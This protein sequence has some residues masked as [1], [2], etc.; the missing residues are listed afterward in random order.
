MSKEK[1]EIPKQDLELTKLL[2][3]QIA[4]DKDE[5]KAMDKNIVAAWC[6]YCKRCHYIWFPKDHS[7]YQTYSREKI[8]DE[9]I[10]DRAPPKSCARCKSKYWNKDPIR[11]TKY[12]DTRDEDWIM[13]PY[14]YRK[15]QTLPVKAK[16]YRSALKFFEELKNKGIL[17]NDYQKNSENFEKW[18]NEGQVDKSWNNRNEWN[19]HV[20]A[21]NDYLEITEQKR[22]EK[23]ERYY[24]KRDLQQQK[25]SQ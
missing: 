20:E 10:L 22:K 24:K 3:Q 23:I 9:G 12:F 8:I 17:T 13:N 25:N 11:K 4:P 5:K 6:Y 15:I 2:V 7:G 16:N 19:M 18:I 14:R 1:N 21:Y